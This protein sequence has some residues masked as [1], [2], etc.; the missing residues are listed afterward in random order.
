MH[1]LY[2][3]ESHCKPVQSVCD[4]AHAPLPEFKLGSQVYPLVQQCPELHWWFV[5]HVVPSEDGGAVQVGAKSGFEFSVQRTY[6]HTPKLSG[7]VATVV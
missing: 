4:L 1:S 7:Q 2:V 3:L 6:P 5:S